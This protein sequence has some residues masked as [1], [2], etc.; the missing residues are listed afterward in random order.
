MHQL[1]NLLDILNF[2]VRLE[3]S[4]RATIFWLNSVLTDDLYSVI[5][6]NNHF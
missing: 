5:N 1:L 2:I 6:I 3:H 4:T